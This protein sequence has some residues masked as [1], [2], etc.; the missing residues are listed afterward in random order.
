[1]PLPSLLIPSAATIT[2]VAGNGAKAGLVLPNTV[3]ERERLFISHPAGWLALDLDGD[4]DGREGCTKTDME[5]IAVKVC[6][7][8]SGCFGTAACLYQKFLVLRPRI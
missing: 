4:G 3:G 2:L 5:I 1:M 8:S 7:C 6:C